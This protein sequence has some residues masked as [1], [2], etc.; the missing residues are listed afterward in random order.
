[1]SELIAKP[2]I[3]NKFWVVEDSGQKIATIQAKDDGGYAYVHDEQREYFPSVKNLKLKYNIPEDYFVFGRVGRKDNF[4]P[5]ALNSLKKIKDNGFD[6]AVI[7]PIVL[8]TEIISLS[9]YVFF[10]KENPVL[11]WPVHAMYGWKEFVVGENIVRIWETYPDYGWAGLTHVKRLGEI[12]LNYPYETYAYI[13]YDSL[14]GD[15][16]LNLIRDGHEGIV[17]PSKRGGEIWKVGL[18]LMIFDKEMLKRILKRIN[19]QDYL[20]YRDYDAFAF[21]HNHIVNPLQLEVSKTPIE[22]KIFYYENVDILNHSEFNGVKYFISSPDEYDEE[23]KIFFFDINETIEIEFFVNSDSN[24]YNVSHGDIISTGLFKDKIHFLG[25]K[26]LGKEIDLTKKFKEIKNSAIEI[27]SQ[28]G[29]NI[30]EI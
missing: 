6:V 5:I 8:S 18:H 25:L 16:H 22:D 28:H 23:I 14:L 30:E 21:L 11:D 2:V 9:D 3:K 19:I 4:H 10:T 29:K 7:S 27:K 24:I 20:S 1:M 15:E 26:Y 13:I 17:F 12:F